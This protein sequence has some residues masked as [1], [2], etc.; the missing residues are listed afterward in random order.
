[1]KSLSKKKSIILEIVLCIT[2]ILSIVGISKRNDLFFHDFPVVAYDTS[3]Y[4]YLTDLDY[5]KELSKVGWGNLLYDKNA[6]GDLISLNVENKRTYFLRGIFAHANSEVI[7]DIRKYHDTYDYFTSYVGLDASRGENGDGV[8]IKVYTSTDKEHWDLQET[9][10]VLKGTSEAKWIQISIQDVNYLKLEAN[11][12]RN[13]TADHAVYGNPRLIVEGFEE[14]K[15]NVD[16]IKTVEEYNELL[17]GKTSDEIMNDSTLRLEL[18]QRNL[19]EK[20]GYDLLEVYA[21]YDED[22]YAMLNW[23]MNDER[24]LEKFTVGGNPVGNYMNALKVLTKLYT[25]HKE[26]LTDEEHKNLY[27]TMMFAISLTHSNSVCFW[28]S[29]EKN[30]RVCSDGVKRYEV[31]KDLYLEEKL[32]T[33]IFESLTVEEMRWVV[34]NQLSDEEIPWLNWY[35]TETKNGNTKYSPVHGH[36]NP[37]TY[38]Y[39]SQGWNYY[40]PTYYGANS[41]CASDAKHKTQAGYLRD[42]SCDS[43]YHLNEFGVNTDSPLVPRLWIVFEEDGVCGSLSKTG[44][45]LLGVYGIPSAVIGQ[46]GHAAYLTP[47]KTYE[48]GKWTTVWNIGNPAAGWA[49]SEKGERFPL[50]WGSKA[51][52]WHSY[53]NV[54]YIVLIQD[55]LN[56]FTNYQESLVKLL[57]AKLYEGN[58]K[59]QEQIYRDVLKKQSFNLDAWKGLID[60]YLKDEEKT[61][62]DYYLLAKE[63]MENMKNYPLPMHDLLKLIEGK[64]DTIN[65]LAF[66]SKQTK[67]LEEVVSLAETQKANYHENYNAIKEMANYLLNNNQNNKI[68]S[69]SFTGENKNAIVLEGIFKDNKVPF[70]YSLD[71]KNTWTNVVDQ[72]TIVPLSETELQKL[73]TTDDIYI[74]VIGSA[75]TEE[76]YF[77][78]DLKEAATPS[79][80]YAND[81]ENKVIGN[82]ENLEWKETSSQEWH[83]LEKDT[84]FSG[85]KTI[86]VRYSNYENYISG[87]AIPL[88]FTED[89]LEK[90][91]T[92]ISIARLSIAEFST[93]HGGEEA[94]KII[95]GNKNTMWHSHYTASADPDKFITIKINDGAFLSKIEYLPRQSSYNGMIKDAVIMVSEDNENWTT[96]VE[97]TNWAYDHHLKTVELEEP[98]YAVYVKIK[99]NESYGNFVSGSMINLFEDTT[100]VKPKKLEIKENQDSEETEEKEL[101]TQPKIEKKVAKEEPVLENSTPNT[102]QEE[103]AKEKEVIQEEQKNETEEAPTIPSSEQNTTTQEE[104]SISK[105]EVTNETLTNES[106]DTL[107]PPTTS[108]TVDDSILNQEPKENQNENSSTNEKSSKEEINTISNAKVPEKEDSN[109]NVFI[110]V[111]IPII[112]VG[113]GLGIFAIV[114]NKN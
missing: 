112:I 114:R 97:H 86:E 42:K 67:T 53:Y 64:I 50:N 1:M 15:L 37:Y 7:Y 81:L 49:A 14:S 24:L 111:L 45:N 28:V 66:R 105:E 21:S 109:M 54:S 4:L 96:V 60:T 70:R 94:T 34:D 48:D 106:K 25:A 103:S 41:Y 47:S 74:Q 17:K 31:L 113:L 51:N 29:G 100:K 61:S 6:D 56:D 85:N 39:Y 10:E 63:I 46:P 84:I 101:E 78:I 3:K 12:Y 55:A 75:D 65:Q 18:L 2:L 73:N 107:Q 35:A 95:D 38:I 71:M 22:A 43:E 23:L 5:D 33:A 62:D 58:S 16:F 13:E 27:E 76:N 26:D 110:I 82:I 90:K 77:V 83:K 80:L 59:E 40:D 108:I 68:A 72:R 88:T 79:G 98:V 69:F 104:N 9:T 11:K 89:I 19:V 20:I 57:T 52:G 92:Y 91:E 93:E 87:E 32:E 30:N 44:S 36:L 102:N 99:A 8:I